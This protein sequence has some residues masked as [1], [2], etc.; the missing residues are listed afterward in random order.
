MQWLYLADF[1]VDARAMPACD[2]TTASSVAC[3]RQEHCRYYEKIWIRKIRIFD[4]GS[5][6]GRLSVRWGNALGVWQVRQAT[7]SGDS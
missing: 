7:R 2:I 1:S 6:Y 4:S 5:T 3:A